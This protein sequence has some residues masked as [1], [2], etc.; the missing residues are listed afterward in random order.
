MS[1]SDWLLLLVLSTFWGGSFFFADIAVRE[2]PPL[3]LALGRCAIAAAVLL[4]Y[5]RVK[6]H[7]L[8][9]EFAIWRSLVFLSLLNSVLPFTLIFWGQ[10]H[11]PS[12]LAS[13]LNAT[14]PLFSIL[15]AH[16]ATSDEKLTMRRAIGVAIGFVGVIIVI[17]INALLA[18]G[19]NVLAQL[20]VV[21]AAF[22]YAS[23]GV[24]G[25][26]FKTL[27]SAVIAASV[28]LLGSLMLL[29][30]VAIV[31]QPWRL[32]APSAGAVASMIGLA[33][34]ST[35]LAFLIYFH[36]L[37]R[38]GATNLQLVAFLIPVSAILLGVGFLGE[39]LEWRHFAGMALI[40]IGLAII[41]GRLERALRRM[42]L[43]G[44]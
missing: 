37:A 13:I 35:A 22:F 9:R 29:P 6:G 41:D 1:L 11:I 23:A 4:L 16:F 10:T 38:A 39:T 24:Y 26:R 12:G 17:G 30:L 27:P 18:L 14:A 3:T 31:E 15:L 44:A 34:V 7:G 33:V 21:L 2:I 5:V 20:A 36:V 28:L 32:P 8:P 43:G 40:A 25:R 42:L 19:V